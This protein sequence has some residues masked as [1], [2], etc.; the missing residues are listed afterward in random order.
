MVHDQSIYL[1][2][3]ASKNIFNFFRVTSLDTYHRD[4]EDFWS[5]YLWLAVRGWM[6]ILLKYLLN[7][8]PILA[9]W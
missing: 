9:H 5:I 7:T 3:I 1:S 6:I 2:V 4:A 8:V